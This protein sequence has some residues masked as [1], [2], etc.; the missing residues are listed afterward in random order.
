[1][2]PFLR[3]RNEVNH[4]SVHPSIQSQSQESLF[5]LRTPTHHPE[6]RSY[7]VCALCCEKDGQGS[8][9]KQ[10]QGTMIIVEESF[11][12]KL[13]VGKLLLAVVLVI[14][15]MAAWSFFSACTF[16]HPSFR[17]CSAAVVAFKKIDLAL[18]KQS[19][20]H[21]FQRG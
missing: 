15:Y 7:I 8:E 10:S 20:T 12:I 2:F 14:Q 18:L 21:L 5:W 19:L 13:R 4:E 9:A 1:M 6:Q 16:L 11:V 3:F 17:P